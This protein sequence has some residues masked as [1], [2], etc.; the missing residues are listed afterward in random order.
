MLNLFY[1]L[2]FFSYM[3]ISLPLQNLNR[4]L[5]H[6]ATIIFVIAYVFVVHCFHKI[7]ANRPYKYA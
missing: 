2:L 4:G 5:R 3:M 1:E 6:C 7:E